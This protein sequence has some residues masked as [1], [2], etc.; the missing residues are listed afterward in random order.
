M[1][2]LPEVETT[3]RGIASFLQDATPEQALVR[4]H[5]L[6]WP[7]DETALQRWCGAPINTIQRRSKYL[8]LSNRNG[9][10]LIHLGMSGS[11]RVLPQDTPAQKH[12]H[13]D[14]LLD[15]D[16]LLRYTDPRRF[17]AWLVHFD[18]D[19]LTHP[20]LARLGPEPLSEAF[21]GDFLHTACQKSRRAIKV[22]IMDSKVVVGVGNIY[23][24]EALFLAGIHPATPANTLTPAQTGTLAD[25]I[26][27]VLA[28]A[29]EQGGTTLQD[30]TQPD[31]NPGYFAQQLN[32]YGRTGEPCPRCGT[33]IE[34]MMLGQRSSFFCPRC[35]P[36]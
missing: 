17:G 26:K 10:L 36:V 33:P 5:R 34:S 12:D 8:I 9:H 16:Q 2:E 21:N 25:A 6:R 30:F 19:P 4:Q 29:I 11:L 18:A 24:N 27:Q 20:L 7:V 28:R 13:I 35:Q 32:V 1:P 14:L 31:G 15:N 23:A 22:L 3:R